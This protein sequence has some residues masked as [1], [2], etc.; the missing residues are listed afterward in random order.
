MLIN[1]RRREL[2]HSL[3]D[4]DRPRPV[5]RLKC[6]RLREI[7]WGLW[8]VSNLTVFESEASHQLI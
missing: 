8:G 6:V 4:T 7:L 2:K 1:N 3:V 5:K